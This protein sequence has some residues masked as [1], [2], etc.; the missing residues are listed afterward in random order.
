MVAAASADGPRRLCLPNKGDLAQADL[1]S[2]LFR[3][4]EGLDEGDEDVRVGHPSLLVFD[5]VAPA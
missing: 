1:L 5:R 3:R 2:H 4:V